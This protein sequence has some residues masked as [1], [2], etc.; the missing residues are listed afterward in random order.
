MGL[1]KA[2][3]PAKKTMPYRK[4]YS[5]MQ[6]FNLRQLNNS[7]NEPIMHRITCAK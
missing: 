4:Y 1:A 6:L 2:V 7:L 3:A 5:N